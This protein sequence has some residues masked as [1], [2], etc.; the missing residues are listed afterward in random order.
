MT[1]PTPA[2]TTGTMP[3][4]LSPLRHV[5][6]VEGDQGGG[7]LPPA[8]SSTGSSIADA[9]T[10]QTAPAVV[11]APTT[12][13]AAPEGAPAEWDGK[14]D[15]LPAG[16]QALIR[17]L[18]GENADRRTKLTTAETQQAE[19]LRAV[20]KAAGIEVPGDAPAPPPAEVT[21]Q[22]ERANSTAREARVELGVY[23]LATAPDAP[24]KVDVGALLDSR[25]FIKATSDLDPDAD[26]FA[27][28]VQA[29]IAAATT[30]NPKL[31]TTQ[32]VTR[33]GADFTGGTGG[34]RTS[35]TP[36]SLDD[37]VAASYGT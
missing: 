22:I 17:D 27:E 10:A 16:A 7:G 18:R 31:L 3:A 5:R 19:L 20:A 12:P 14:V 9:V 30:A 13:P 28:K 29:A 25:T 1:T 34:E 32:A 21:A 15:S 23:R 37:A 33:S 36:R 4:A 35:R 24:V 6:F 11:V 26:D 8:P 2:R